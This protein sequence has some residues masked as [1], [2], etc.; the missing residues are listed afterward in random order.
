LWISSSN[1]A[2]N[3]YETNTIKATMTSADY[4]KSKYQNKKMKTVENVE[5]TNSSPDEVETRSHFK[6]ASDEEASPV[7][8]QKKKKSKKKRK[9]SVDEAESSEPVEVPPKEKKAKKRK[10]ETV[11]PEAEAPPPVPEPKPKSKKSA[12]SKSII[13]SNAAY[14]NDDVGQTVISVDRFAV[15][16]LN[17]L[18]LE[19]FGHSNVANIIG[20]GL[21]ENLNINLLNCQTLQN[22]K[23]NKYELYYLMDRKMSQKNINFK[24]KAKKAVFV[25][26]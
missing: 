3:I 22:A 11:T 20:Y 26:I 23:C 21:T 8:Q 17:F 18:D 9:A 15:D 5:E 6:Q 4:F 13:C 25:P 16:K 1:E 10:T 14:S 19:T 2:T 12:V 24:M 7:E